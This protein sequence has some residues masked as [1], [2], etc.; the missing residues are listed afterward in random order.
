MEPYLEEIEK[1]KIEISQKDELIKQKDEL[2]KELTS[3][4]PE[5]YIFIDIYSEWT[6]AIPFRYSI[7]GLQIK[8]K[9][10]E[11]TGAV[12]ERMTLNVSESQVLPCEQFKK[13]E[14]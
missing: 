11:R 10:Q 12:P 6:L 13:G 2:I 1:M 9:I 14:V 7:T 8:Q 4:H 3:T 5:Q